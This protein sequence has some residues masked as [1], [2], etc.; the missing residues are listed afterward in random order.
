MNARRIP[1]LPLFCLTRGPQ[2]ST[3]EG[4]KTPILRMIPHRN[5]E[6]TVMKPSILSSICLFL[7]EIVLFVL[8]GIVPATALAQTTTVE[9]VAHSRHEANAWMIA[10]AGLLRP[11]AL[12]QIGAGRMRIMLS[13]T[14]HPVK[15]G[16]VDRTDA[17]KLVT[18][19]Q[20]LCANRTSRAIHLTCRSEE[21]GDRWRVHLT[22]RM[23][24]HAD[25]PLRRYLP[26]TCVRPYLT[27]RLGKSLVV[28]HPGGIGTQDASPAPSPGHASTNESPPP[29]GGAA[30]S[31]ETVGIGPANPA[32]ARIVTMEYVTGPSLKEELKD[33]LED[34]IRENARLRN[35]LRLTAVLA[36]LLTLVLL[37][38]ATYSWWKKRE[39]KEKTPPQEPRAPPKTR[40]ITPPHV[41][42]VEIH[43]ENPSKDRILDDWVPSA[44]FLRAVDEIARIRADRDAG[45]AKVEELLR[46]MEELRTELDAL[47][48]HNE[49]LVELSGYKERVAT[50]A[51]RET[52]RLMALV[53][54]LQAR[55]AEQSH[56][57]AQSEE[58]QP[59]RAPAPRPSIESLFL[60][61][62][63][64]NDASGSYPAAPDPILD[65]D[66]PPIGANAPHE[67]TFGGPI[68]GAD[69]QIGHG[70]T[71][72]YNPHAS[73]NGSTFLLDAW[74]KPP[75][76]YSSDLANALKETQS[77]AASRMA[78]H[79]S[80]GFGPDSP[81]SGVSNEATPGE[82][83]TPK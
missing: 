35:A 55:L 60:S 45:L 26:P 77:P 8:V 43:V 70:I 9:T 76:S 30:V 10:N 31:Q 19:L 53:A 15:Y 56:E 61:E 42:S 21:P 17:P 34:V 57:P 47:H 72:N 27:S 13:S 59:A 37:G 18:V 67:Q 12:E 1:S 81:R 62:E 7:M 5:T 44:Q 82:I 41:A 71:M 23:C 33:R 6:E 38:A 22:D 32:N 63:S 3:K 73:V 64:A 4:R 40:T 50:E 83:S 28:P 65:R 24:A 80:P 52:A 49:E 36:L 29:S 11:E 68:P 46:R 69:T 66:H 16:L 48:E 74:G 79:T 39:Q 2:T 54:E 14:L 20:I 58:H 25:E 51:T 78:E 75:P